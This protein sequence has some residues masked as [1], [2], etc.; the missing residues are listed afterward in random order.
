MNAGW[1]PR[2]APTYDLW[3][4]A[5]FLLVP[6]IRPCL[7][8]EFKV[9]KRPEAAVMDPIKY[10]EGGI[11]RTRIFIEGDESIPTE[12]HFSLKSHKFLMLDKSCWRTE[13]CDAAPSPLEAS[14]LSVHL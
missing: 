1:A 13:Q 9:I 14:C 5:D 3:I 11:H 12:N 7:Q 10:A 6:N 8:T 4:F 2:L